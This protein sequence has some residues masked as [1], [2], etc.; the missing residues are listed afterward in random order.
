LWISLACAGGCGGSDHSHLKYGDAAQSLYSEGLEDFYAA[1]CLDAEP[2]FRKV[3]TDYPYS[4]FAALAE[5]RLADCLYED[6]KYIEAI[7]A[8]QQFVRHRPSHVEVPYARFKVAECYYEQIPD[9]WFLVPP[10]HERD[11]APAQNTLRQLKKFLL[12]Y[13]DDPHLPRAR[14]MAQETLELL[15]RH[16]LYAA[17]FYLDR[18]HPKAAVGRLETLLNSYPK[19]SV[20]AEALL[21]LGETYLELENRAEARR[22]FQKLIKRFPGSDYADPAREHVGSL[23]P[24]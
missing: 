5:L 16:E 1:N 3:R 14:Q 22:T 10:A 11:Q 20:E 13:K 4:R 8:Y 7:Q 21:L 15:A 9:D 18:D 12:D 17:R 6:G 19:S 23:G 2:T 24:G